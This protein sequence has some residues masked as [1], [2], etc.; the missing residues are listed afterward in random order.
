MWL[1]LHGGLRV[2]RLL[3]WRLRIPKDNI[4]ETRQQLP[5]L[6][7]PR[8]RSYI[9]SPPLCSMGQSSHEPF[10][11]QWEGT[12]RRA[13]EFVTMFSNFHRVQ[14]ISKN[15]TNSTSPFKLFIMFLVSNWFLS[16]YINLFLL[17]CDFFHCFVI[18]F[19]KLFSKCVSTKSRTLSVTILGEMTLRS[20]DTLSTMYSGCIHL[21]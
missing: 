12:Q 7:W 10:Q 18:H 4:P 5:G 8:L 11:I 9:V 19:L 15:K 20:L 14:N 6:L 17:L 16:T 21:I 2:L 1:L 3:N 13:K